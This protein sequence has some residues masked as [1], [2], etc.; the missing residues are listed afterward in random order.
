MIHQL[1]NTYYIAGYGNETI[2]DIEYDALEWL[3]YSSAPYNMY[4][5]SLVPV[6]SATL[7]DRQPNRTIYADNVSHM[8][9][10]GS[11]DEANNARCDE[12]LDYIVQLISGDS[13]LDGYEYLSQ[14]MRI[15]NQEE[16]A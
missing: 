4:G 10:A 2:I 5:D 13:S 1:V 7:G 6:W 14:E 15:N 3:D 9:L 8:E 16:G 12:C 11:T